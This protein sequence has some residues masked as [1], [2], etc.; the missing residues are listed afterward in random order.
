MVFLSVSESSKINYGANLNI[1][2]SIMKQ[3]IQRYLCTH[4]AIY[5]NANKTAS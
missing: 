2:I 1:S 4:F 5:I 3:S